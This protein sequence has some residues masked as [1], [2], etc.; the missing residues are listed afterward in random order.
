MSKYE[1][2]IGLHLVNAELI[3][4]ARYRGLTTYQRI[5]QIGQ[6]PEMGNAMS[7]ATGE[8]LGLIVEQE[9]REGR[10]MWSA[11][12]VGTSGSP[13]EGFYALAKQ[14]GKLTDDSKAGKETFWLAERKAVYEAWSIKFK[15]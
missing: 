2:S 13:G 4:A 5:A 9:I 15:K 12:C 8:V 14:L 3:Y 7:A 10:P 1:G 6:L 11:V